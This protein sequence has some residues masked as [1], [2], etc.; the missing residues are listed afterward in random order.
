MK[1]ALT[2]V[3]SDYFAADGVYSTYTGQIACG[4]AASAVTDFPVFVGELYVSSCRPVNRAKPQTDS[5]P[6]RPSQLDRLVLQQ[7]SGRT[8]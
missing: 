2:S 3:F 1:R 6:Y 5:L 8:C 7:H 4:Q